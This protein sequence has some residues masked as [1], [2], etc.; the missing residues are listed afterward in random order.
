MRRKPPAGLWVLPVTDR[1]FSGGSPAMLDRRPARFC[2]LAVTAY[3][4]GR[5]LNLGT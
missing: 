5:L 1:V 2:A 4:L 3:F